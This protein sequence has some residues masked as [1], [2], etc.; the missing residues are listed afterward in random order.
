MHCNIEF[1]DFVHAKLF[2]V[3]AAH[4]FKTRAD[5]IISIFRLHSSFLLFDNH[6]D[7]GGK[8]KV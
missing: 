5:L 2:N 3:P 6:I 7:K 8:Q 4:A 1:H